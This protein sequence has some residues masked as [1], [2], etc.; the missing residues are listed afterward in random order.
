M[1]PATLIP[2]DVHARLSL[3]AD[4]DALLARGPVTEGDAGAVLPTLADLAA[5]AILHHQRPLALALCQ[6]VGLLASLTAPAV[7]E[8]A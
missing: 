5:Q 3:P 8:V 6:A 7:A 2:P 4:C 1:A